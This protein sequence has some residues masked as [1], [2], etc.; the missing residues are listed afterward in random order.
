MTTTHVIYLLIGAALAL[1]GAWGT[2]YLGKCNC[3]GK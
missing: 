1:G 3:A 2:G